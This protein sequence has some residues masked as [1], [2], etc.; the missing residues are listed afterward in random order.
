[1]KLAPTE[2]RAR[3]EGCHEQGFGWALACCG[4]D[5]HEAKETLQ[6]SYLKVLEGRARFRGESSFET[7]LFAVIRRTAGER[8]RRQRAKRLALLRLARQPAPA[9][10][11]P[12]AEV[13]SGRLAARLREGLASLS[14]R[15][16]EVLHL[17]FYGG[18]TIE[19]ASEAMG[20]SLGS[21]RT[22]YAR[23]KS[24]LRTLLE[25]AS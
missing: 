17:V 12:A 9:S 3:L 10:P 16:R 2:L 18:L 5:E 8:R 24:R 7:W 13:A 22:H 21:A 15:Q 20:V 11:D 19:Q 6:V 1:V 23:G 4:W 25:D 14:Q